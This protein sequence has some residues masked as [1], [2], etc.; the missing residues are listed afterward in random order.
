MTYSH[1][2]RGALQWILWPAAAI[3]FAGAVTARGAEAGWVSAVLIA[4]GLIS[5]FISFC[6]LTLTVSDGGSGLDVR[7]G[8]VGLFHKQVPYASI[9]AAEPA[10]SS[11]LD[12]FG[13]HWVPGRGWTWN[14]W[15]FDCV[16][17]TVDDRTLRIG[18]DD[19]EG[20]ATFLQQRIAGHESSVRNEET[21]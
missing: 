17:L 10:R 13:V 15:G 8:P 4:A 9:T 16:E 2:Q 1:T 14:L 18:T 6:F 5:I 20:L 7:F 3:C 11:L 19:R 12:G 21:T